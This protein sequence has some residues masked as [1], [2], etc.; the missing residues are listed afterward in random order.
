MCGISAK[1]LVPCVLM[2]HPLHGALWRALKK[3][4]LEPNKGRAR[5]ELLTNWRV[6]VGVQPNPDKWY[7]S[8]NDNGTVT[9]YSIS[10][11]I[12]VGAKLCM[13]DPVYKEIDIHNQWFEHDRRN[14][15]HVANQIG[16]SKSYFILYFYG[17]RLGKPSVVLYIY[18]RL[19]GEWRLN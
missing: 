7:Q 15:H 18:D 5:G 11:G 12:Q 2:S 3:K 9:A 17:V 4:V 10:G 13:K 6:T 14:R 8:Y 19:C 16:S 1:T